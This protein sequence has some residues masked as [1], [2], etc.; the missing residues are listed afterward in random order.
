MLRIQSVS[1]Q[2]SGVRINSEPWIVTGK[3]DI[4]FILR[5]FPDS[6]NAILT[7]NLSYLAV[8]F[9]TVGSGK[10]TGGSHKDPGCPIRKFEVNADVILYFNIMPFPLMADSLNRNRH[11]A[12]PY[13]KIQ[14][15]RTLVQQHTTAF[16]GPC[17]A[18]GS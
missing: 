3:A 11:P 13:Q 7:D 12:K 4:T 9:K 10:V 18:P 5:Q 15:M 8:Y 16:A 2:N 14:L 17:G 1:P 6:C